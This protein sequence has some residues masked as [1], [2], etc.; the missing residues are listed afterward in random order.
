M[1]LETGT[2]KILNKIAII[3]INVEEIRQLEVDTSVKVLDAHANASLTPKDD[4]T[5]ARQKMII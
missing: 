4:F 2:I 3:K 1:Q 5:H